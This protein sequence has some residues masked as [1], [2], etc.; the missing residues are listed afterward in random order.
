VPLSRED[1]ISLLEHI[2]S[3]DDDTVEHD[4]CG[5]CERSR[6]EAEEADRELMGRDP[7]F[8]RFSER[9]ENRWRQTKYY[10]LYQ[11]LKG[12]GLTYKQIEAEFNDKGWEM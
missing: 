6:I 3:K 12:R 11:E 2:A 8:E 4:D 9:V 5:S 1:E 10:K 7:S